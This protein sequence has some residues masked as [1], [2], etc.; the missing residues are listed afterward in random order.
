MTTSKRISKTD[1]AKLLKRL[2]AKTGRLQVCLESKWG[3]DGRTRYLTK[4]TCRYKLSNYTEFRRVFKSCFMYNPLRK[5]DPIDAMLDY[6][7]FHF[8]GRIYT[9]VG[10]QYRVG[11]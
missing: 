1:F 10:K 5:P 8:T 9:V 3:S 2:R 11:K 6:D 4:S 7:A